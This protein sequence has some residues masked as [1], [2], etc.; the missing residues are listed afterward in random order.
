MKFFPA[1]SVEPLTELSH[2]REFSLRNI[3]EETGQR[4]AVTCPRPS[5][6]SRTGLELQSPDSLPRLLVQYPM[7]EA[8][9]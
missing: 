3:D 7:T 5:Q 1:W 9:P 8:V 4:G 2:H 6:S